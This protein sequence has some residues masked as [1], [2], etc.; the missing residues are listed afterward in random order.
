MKTLLTYARTKKH[1]QANVEVELLGFP[2]KLL[3]IGYMPYQYDIPE[4]AIA[5]ESYAILHSDIQSGGRRFPIATEISFNSDKFEMR[6]DIKLYNWYS[7]DK[8]VFTNPLQRNYV[9]KTALF[10]TYPDSFVVKSDSEAEYI[11]KPGECVF[12]KEG[13]VIAVAE[14]FMCLCRYM[15]LITGKCETM[16]QFPEDLYV[17]K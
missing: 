13:T 8:G 16:I 3:V 1:I 7:V 12:S 2:P 4:Q 10:K 17:V 6:E 11:P 5:S 9:N 15:N 14:S